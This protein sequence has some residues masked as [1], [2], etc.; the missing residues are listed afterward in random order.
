[1]I[2]CAMM[3]TIDILVAPTLPRF[4]P[5]VFF[6]NL[7]KTRLVLERGSFPVYDAET[8]RPFLAPLTLYGHVTGCFIGKLKDF[9]ESLNFL[10]NN[11]I[12]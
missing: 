2:S 1:M 7:A 9:S 10:I 4:I 6:R 12:K 3:S 5:L 8:P 11:P